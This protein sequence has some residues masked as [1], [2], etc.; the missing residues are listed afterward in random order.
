MRPPVAHLMRR[1]IHWHSVVQQPLQSGDVALTGRSQERCC[2][3][4]TSTQCRNDVSVAQRRLENFSHIAQKGI[5]KPRNYLGISTPHLKRP[6]THLYSY[7]QTHRHTC[8]VIS[9]HIVVTHEKQS[10][11]MVMYGLINMYN[12]L[13]RER[14]MPINRTLNA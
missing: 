8:L 10:L 6:P 3:P 13:M 14:N 9:R 7:K 11:C 2:L 1:R 12:H 5:L 4:E